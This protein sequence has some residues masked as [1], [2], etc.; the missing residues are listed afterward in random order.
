MNFRYPS[1]IAVDASDNV[2]VADTFNHRIQQFD[3]AGNFISE[4]GSEGSG[5]GS[6]N[7]PFGVAADSSGTI[8]VADTF[9]HRIQQFDISHSPCIV[10]SIFGE[11]DLY[12]DKMRDFRDRFLAQSAPGGRLIDLYVI[13]SS[14]AEPLI[15]K[16]P[17]AKKSARIMLKSLA[18]GIDLVIR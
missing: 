16:S 11:T 1:G 3:T 12:T 7:L 2:F 6:F 4:W 17:L 8:Y 9:N 14:V 13:T 15:E 5:N 10:S 18:A